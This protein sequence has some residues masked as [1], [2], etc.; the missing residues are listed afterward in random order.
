M[1]NKNKIDTPK[2]LML[3]FAECPLKY[4]VDVSSELCITLN[5]PETYNWFYSSYLQISWEKSKNR[6]DLY[7]VNPYIKHK[8]NYKINNGN[9]I[10]FVKSLL[11][12]GYYV[13]VGI[14]DFYVPF[15]TPHN[16]MHN[17]HPSVVIGYNDNLQIFKI[18]GF[19]NKNIY[20]ITDI[21]YAEFFDAYN[22]TYYENNKLRTSELRTINYK[23]WRN[24][25][26]NK[27]VLK[28]ILIDYIESENSYYKVI[29][30]NIF[31]KTYRYIARKVFSKFDNNKEYGMKFY[32]N[33]IEYIHNLNGY[34]NFDM[35]TFQIFCEHKKLICS[36]IEYFIENNYIIND[37]ELY[38][39]CKNIKHKA[40]VL[41][42]TCIKLVLTST[43]LD[44]TAK[45]KLVALI[46]EI[47]LLEENIYI[48]LIELL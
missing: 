42:N 24:Y 47:K 20:R 22:S 10:N 40:V 37:Q 7:G 13:Y 45:Q 4:R 31:F 36:R 18:A 8:R 3:S 6:V 11:V 16:K 9:I 12:K 39:N 2:E 34:S 28:K 25:K 23:K 14:D 35:A 43:E 15:R 38:C 48:R 44:K 27:N 29:Y 30:S 5:H 17:I 19:D 33:F 21:L 32:N 46:E 41:K 26:F 1:K